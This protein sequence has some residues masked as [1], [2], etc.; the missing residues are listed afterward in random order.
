MPLGCHSH[1]WSHGQRPRRLYRSVVVTPAPVRVLPNGRLSRVLRSVV[2]Y[3]ENFSVF[4][5]TS[6]CQGSLIL[7]RKRKQ[8]KMYWKKDFFSEPGIRGFLLLIQC[9]L[10]WKTHSNVRPRLESL[11]YVAHGISTRR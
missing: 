9:P 1:P 6:L 10:Y 3:G 8:N 7:E 2:G 11:S 5:R 4:P